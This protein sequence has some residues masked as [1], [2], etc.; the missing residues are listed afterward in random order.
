ML[1]PLVLSGTRTVSPEPDPSGQDAPPNVLF[2]MTDDQN[3]DLGCYGHPLV[4]SPHIDQ[5]AARGLRFERA[6]CQY[7]VCNPSRSSLLT[8][9]YPDQSGVLTNADSFRVHHPELPTLPQWFR[10]NGYTSARVGKIFHYGVPGQIGTP[11]MDDPASWDVTVNPRGVDKDVEDEIHTLQPGRFGG[12]LSWLRV[13]APDS[14]FTDAIGAREAVRLME[15]HHPDRTGKPLFLA[16]GFYRPHTPYVAPG[17]YFDLYPRDQIE[18]PEDPPDDRLD[19]PVAALH[20]RAHQLEL[21]EDQRREIIQAYYAATSHM[22]A[23]VGVL[24]DG[25]ERHGLTENTIVVFVSDHG[26][27]LG[28]HG[29]WQ[30]SDLFEG[31]ARVPLIIADPRQSAIGAVTE[32]PVELVDLYPTLVDLTGLPA[33]PHLM[34]HSLRPMLD[35]AEASIRESA[36]TV[37]WSR[38]HGTRSGLRPWRAKGYTI[39]TPRFRY[40]EWEGGRHGAELYDYV[41][42]PYEH[43]NLVGTPENAEVEAYLRGL[44][45]RRVEAAQS[46]AE[47]SE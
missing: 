43:V 33:P 32:A 39:R 11:G 36:L 47:W 46:S 7:P 18:L 21:T 28:R 14:A 41:T 12:T 19:I 29:L 17:P 5:L 3:N 10:Q 13:E 30:K 31:S 20:D 23:Q 2:I 25:L 22:D 1:L 45:R 16:V 38:A 44:L 4:Q 6:Y 9:L 37:T 42:D 24:M 15:T 35:D 27:H 40:T 8:G 26:Y 34:G